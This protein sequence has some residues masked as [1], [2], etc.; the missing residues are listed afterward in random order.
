MNV[1]NNDKLMHIIKKCQINAL[2]IT[3]W[4]QYNKQNQ[5]WQIN[6]ILITICGQI[7]KH[8]QKRQINDKK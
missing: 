7:D 5:T 1:I 8:N 6:D 3:N 4:W 2:L